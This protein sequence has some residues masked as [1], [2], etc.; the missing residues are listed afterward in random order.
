MKPVARMPKTITAKAKLREVIREAGQF[1]WPVVDEALEVRLRSVSAPIRPR[2]GE[3]NAALKICGPGARVTAE[4]VR[5]GFLPE[6][7][8]AAARISQLM[9]D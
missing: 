2:S 7:P 9:L 8:G 5:A 6:L 4:E 3:I 1:G